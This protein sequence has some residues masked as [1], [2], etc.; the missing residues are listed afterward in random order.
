M[1][2]AQTSA[3]VLGEAA[4]LSE[5]RRSETDRSVLALVIDRH[6][7]PSPCLRPVRKLL[8]FP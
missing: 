6:P 1:A 3:R 7:G 2:L 8:L 4:V 5:T